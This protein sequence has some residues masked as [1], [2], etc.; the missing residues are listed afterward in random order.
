MKE[1]MKDKNLEWFLK[2][3]AKDKKKRKSKG[4]RRVILI[5]VA[6]TKEKNMMKLKRDLAAHNLDL[7]QCD[8]KVTSRY[9]GTDKHVARWLELHALIPEM[10]K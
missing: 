2:Q 10:K 4:C 9:M 8:G 5:V 7:R 3:E 6:D 1:E